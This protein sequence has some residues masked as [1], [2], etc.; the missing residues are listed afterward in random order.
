MSRRSPAEKLPLAIAL[1]ANA[2]R[3]VG[4]HIMNAKRRSIFDF[5]K[6][7]SGL[8][9]E[10]IGSDRVRND[11]EVIGD[12]GISYRMNIVILAPDKAHP[13]AFIETIAEQDAV[14]GRF[15]A[16]YDI[17]KNE[18]VRDIQRV[19]VYDDRHEWR[20]GDLILLQDVS[21]IVP[22]SNTKTRIEALAH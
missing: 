4:D 1:V 6:E 13:L 11:E 9:A 18:S 7:V 10:T 14:T 5:K 16:F 15:R 3:V 2:S 22:F 20:A 12:S 8:A 21:N 19:S 17:G